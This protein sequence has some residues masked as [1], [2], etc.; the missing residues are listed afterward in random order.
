[1]TDPVPMSPSTTIASAALPKV[2]YGKGGHVYDVDGKCYV[3]GSGGPAVYS[4]GYG[5]E[6]VIEAIHHQLTRVMHGYRHT[7][8]SDPLEEL[9]ALIAE[10]CG[11]D[12]DQMVFVSG[13]SEAVESAMKI[14]LQY[15][16]AR[17]EETRRRFI[18]RQRSWHGNTLGAL[19]ISGFKARREAYEGA[20]LPS[21]LLSPANVYRPPPGV[22]PADVAAFCADELE[23][24]I[25]RLGAARV[26][27]FVFEPVVGAAGGVVPAP[28]GYAARIREICDRYG[29]LM[30]ADEVM[31]GSG[32][33]GTFRALA[34]DGVAPDIMAIAKGLGGGYVPLGATVYRRYIGEVLHARHG[35]PQ[36]AHT[37]TGHTAACAAGVAVQKIMRREGLFDHVRTN[38][39]RLFGL[40]R[41]ALGAI[42]AVG[43]IRGRGYFAGIE[44]VADRESKQPF[45]PAHKLFLRVRQRSLANGLI[46][47]PSGGNVDGVA[48][49]T[50]ILAPRY[51]SPDTELVEI[52]EKLA[53]SIKEA[54]AQIGAS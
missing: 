21:C 46:C 38:S 39:E 13:G 17:G 6:E 12:L 7:F 44:L 27:A 20:L 4:L 45:D 42:V 11:A 40:L 5:N 28:L 3:D 32:R 22:A 30:I 14:A 50:I 18:S 31:C 49:D 36:T 16:S 25:L 43:D 52:V 48:G 10:Q 47:Y 23:Q 37:F 29:V 34:H 54:L 8:T 35:G 41:E 53:L 26:A 33:T 9:T 51:D 15:H 1:M 19:S 24:A 2:A